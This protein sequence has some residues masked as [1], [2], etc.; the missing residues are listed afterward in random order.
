MVNNV[1]QNDSK[2]WV[3]EWVPKVCSFKQ[4]LLMVLFIKPGKVVLPRNLWMEY[5][6]ERYNQELLV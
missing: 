5:S 4:H 3:R 2:F 1:V 6:S